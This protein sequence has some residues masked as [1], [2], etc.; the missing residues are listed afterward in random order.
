MTKKLLQQSLETV[1]E[2]QNLKYNYV[3]VGYTGYYEMALREAS[4]NACVNNDPSKAYHALSRLICKVVFSWRL[5][6]YVN[7]PFKRFFTNGII[8]SKFSDNKPLC[9]FLLGSSSLSYVPGLVQ[10]IRKKYNQAKIVLHCTDKVSFYEKQFG[11]ARFWHLAKSCDI[12]ASYNET[13]A[14][15]YGFYV[16]PIVISKYD[17]EFN[18]AHKSDILF[19]GQERGRLATLHSIYQKATASGL[20]CDFTIIG[21]DGEKRLSGTN[22]NYDRRL[23]YTEVLEKIASTKC[24][25][26]IPQQGVKGLS[27]RDFEAVANRKYLLTNNESAF[28]NGLFG[29]GQVIS[30]DM[31]GNADYER[32]IHQYNGEDKDL[33]G[34]S[35]HSRLKWIETI[36]DGGKIKQ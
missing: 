6:K 33:S 9:F 8:Q 20:V 19:V 34:Y 28:N 22:I 10:S 5:N 13:D 1:T 3:M 7:M 27:L 11:K 17:V 12:V 23:S 24:I 35:W 31:D 21:V 30:V 36:L 29:D 32:I 16:M 26:N 15:Q 2:M 18:E 4:E 25:L 14:K